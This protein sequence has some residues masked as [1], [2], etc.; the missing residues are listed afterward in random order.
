[1]FERVRIDFTESG[2]SA[3][4]WKALDGG[5]QTASDALRAALRQLARELLDLLRLLT[6]QEK[7]FP[8]PRGIFVGGSDRK[9]AHAAACR[10]LSVA[11]EVTR[12]A[13]ADLVAVSDAEMRLRRV[14]QLYEA[15]LRD[16]AATVPQETEEACNQLLA[17]C[18]EAHRFCTES[19]SS[20][21][22][23]VHA[24]ADVEHEGEA[25]E[26]IAL[27][28]LVGELRA[29]T[30]QIIKKLQGGCHGEIFTGT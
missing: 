30:E 22:G 25:C 13:Y 14:R 2:D 28:R 18:E 7:S 27:L 4:P 10:L 23:R 1:M 12:G 6:A 9:A 15:E 20:F 29:R 3:E 26:P 24:L 8:I 16:Q 17:L 11:E 5:I 19:L 21:L